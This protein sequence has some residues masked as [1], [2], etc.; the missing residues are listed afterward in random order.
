MNIYFTKKGF[1]RVECN[2]GVNK[3]AHTHNI[4][5][6]DYHKYATSIT[7]C[8]TNTKQIGN[9]NQFSKGTEDLLIRGSYYSIE[10]CLNEEFCNIGCRCKD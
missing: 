7:N 3:Q 2:C 1:A 4:R 8:L 10:G 5:Y 6:N 9:N